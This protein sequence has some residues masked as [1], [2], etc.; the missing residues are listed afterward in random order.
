MIA[1]N[2]NSHPT[3]IAAAADDTLRD[4]QKSVALTARA[5]IDLSA[6]PH[7]ATRRRLRP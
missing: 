5:E 4:D 1:V 2:P 6:D 3:F 7:R